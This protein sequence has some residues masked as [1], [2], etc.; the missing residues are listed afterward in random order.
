LEK[1]KRL[2]E[3]NDAAAVRERDRLARK[4]GPNHPRVR[5]LTARLSYNQKLF[6]GLD[7]EIERTRVPAKPFAGSAWRVH[8]RI[9]NRPP[10]T[11]QGRD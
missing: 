5:K 3:I 2:Q 10:R 6:T 4:Y 9:C 8:G 1:A 7:A 11:R